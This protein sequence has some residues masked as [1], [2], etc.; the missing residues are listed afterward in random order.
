MLRRYHDVLLHNGVQNYS[1]DEL[2]YD[3]RAS[4]ARAL[5]FLL[6]AWKPEQHQQDWKRIETGLN[7]FLKLD[8]LAIYQSG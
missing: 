8:G 5:S 3:Y 6:V 2:Q 1:W 4:I 7:A